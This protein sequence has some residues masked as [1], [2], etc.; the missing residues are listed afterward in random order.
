MDTIGKLLNSLGKITRTTRVL[1]GSIASK[2]AKAQRGYHSIPFK[3][4]YG[5]DVHTEAQ[6]QP[7]LA[8][9]GSESLDDTRPFFNGKGSNADLWAPSLLLAR[10]GRSYVVTY[11]LQV[12]RAA[13]PVCQTSYREDET[14]P[15][16]KTILY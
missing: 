9:A 5:G 15:K 10:L 14:S 1:N 11:T 4:E 13:S 6:P 3:T 7:L 2:M 16:R 8:Y 12:S